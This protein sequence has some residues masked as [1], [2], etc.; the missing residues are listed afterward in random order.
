MNSQR[1]I[2]FHKQFSLF[3]KGCIQ[4]PYH[5]CADQKNI[6]WGGGGGG[7]GADNVFSVSYCDWSSSAVRP[8]TSLKDIS[9]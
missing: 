9:S 8:Y 6:R 3:Y 1:D 4:T 7:G 5:A 2:N